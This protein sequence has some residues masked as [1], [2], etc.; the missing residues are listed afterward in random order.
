M[1]CL[2]PKQV[3][4]PIK[5]E[6]MPVRCG[7][8]LPCRSFKAGQWTVRLKEQEK[9]S[10]NS[11]FITLTLDDEN[12]PWAYDKPTLSKRDLQLWFKTIR[13]H[14]PDMKFK[15]YAVGEYGS[16]T[17]RPH[18]H[19]L[20]FNTEIK[21]KFIFE[22]LVEYSWNKGF[23]HVGEITEASIR[24]VAGYLE[25]GIM[26]EKPLE[27]VQRLFSL[28]SKGIGKGYIETHKTYHE[29]TKKFEYSTGGGSYISL[30]RYYRDKIFSQNDK[31]AYSEAIK[32]SMDKEKPKG[33]RAETNHYDAL[34]NRVIAKQN[35]KNKRK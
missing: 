17:N 22:K 8:C 12:L 35:L 5:G 14:Y 21:E 32:I 27:D 34:R 26:G 24:Y 13:N 20:M 9:C 7:K 33:V 4:N 3:V 23:I 29:K 18:Y 28:M 1:Q 19:V 25:K 10:K 6:I 30:P 16:Q 2:K 31:E 11:Y 15:Y